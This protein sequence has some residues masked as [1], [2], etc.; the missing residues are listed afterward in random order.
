MPPELDIG[1]ALRRLERDYS[2]GRTFYVH[3]FELR[4]VRRHRSDW[5]GRLRDSL[6]AGTWRPS[7]P[8]IADV[9]KPGAAVRP[10][11]LLSLADQV[12]YTAAVGQALE[13]ILPALNW[14]IP[15]KDYA[16]QTWKPETEDWISVQFWCWE[17][18]RKRSLELLSDAAVVAITDITGFYEHIDHHTLLSDLRRGGVP[19]DLCSL[20][21]TCLSRWSLLNGRGLP[22]NLT[23]SHLLAKL[24]L[25]IVDQGLANRGYQHVRYVDDIR[26]FCRDTA[27]AKNAL[28]CLSGLLRDRGLSLQSAKTELI[29]PGPAQELFSG[30][31]TVLAPLAKHYVE[32][33]ARQI[34]RSPKYMTVV[35]AEKYVKTGEASIPA[36]MLRAVYDAHFI[37]A[38]ASFEKTLFHFLILRLGRAGDRFAIDH[39]LTLL[40]THPD[41]TDY[42]LS[43]LSATGAVHTTEDRLLDFF[44]SPDALYDYQSYQLLEWRRSVD[45]QP[46]DRMLAYTRKI[47]SEP[48]APLYLRSAARACLGRFVNDAHLDELM[49]AYGAA[50]SELERAELVC[51]LSRVEKTKRNGFLGK[52]KGDG[53]LVDAAIRAVKEGYEFNTG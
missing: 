53:F 44:E 21:T 4:L 27:S 33:I 9:P 34:G 28:L 19:D 8:P 2:R 7:T 31:Q 14:V 35:E 41:E 50:S 23:A 17:R 36:A 46:S 30:A 5:L 47:C 39:V 38:S 37:K 13:H 16:N 1:L 24:Y 6:E 11:A 32:D 18:F 29:L 40:D 42:V 48:S 3:P 25:T 43:Y 15:P 49:R 22:Q 20:L 51:S 12:V 45:D 52:L 26:L 10:A